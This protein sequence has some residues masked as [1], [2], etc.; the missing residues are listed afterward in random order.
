MIE[1]TLPKLYFDLSNCEESIFDISIPSKLCKII[2]FYVLNV[3]E[4]NVDPL[5][6]R[7]P[8]KLM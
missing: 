2:S 1:S 3:N 6:E 8:K 7:G 4:K 5:V